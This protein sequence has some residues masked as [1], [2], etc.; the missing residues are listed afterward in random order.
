MY[1]SFVAQL[2]AVS[3][4]VLDVHQQS[5]NRNLSRAT[6]RQEKLPR[7]EDV[8]AS[9]LTASHPPRTEGVRSVVGRMMKRIEKLE[10]TV[11]C[12]AAEHQCLQVNGHSLTITDTLFS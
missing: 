10:R 5:P 8:H 7:E 4:G 9:A 3:N 1:S 2:T 6:A 11:L 12:L